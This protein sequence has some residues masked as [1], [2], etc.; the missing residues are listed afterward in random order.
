MR[1]LLNAIRTLPAAE[2][3]RAAMLAALTT[4]VSLA[5]PAV[6]LAQALN[7]NLGT[8][9]GLTERVVQLIGLMT[10]LSLV[11]VHRDHDHLVH[12]DRGGP[13]PAA[14]RASATCSRARPTR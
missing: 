14:N 7:I 9:A 3:R 2:W 4:L 12:P 1:E 10:V 6:A 13:L 5:F 11:A 8:G